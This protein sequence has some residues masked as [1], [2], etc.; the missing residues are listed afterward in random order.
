MLCVSLIHHWLMATED[1]GADVMPR[2][3][4]YVTR[5]KRYLVALGNLTL[6][7]SQQNIKGYE[8]Y[9]QKKICALEFY[10]LYCD[11]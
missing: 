10:F 7:L 3:V 11:I 6:F 5:R 4:L 8:I 2:T 1:G 9:V